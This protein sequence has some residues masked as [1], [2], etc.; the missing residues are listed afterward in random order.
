MFLGKT[1]I[2]L[3]L[4]NISVD[5]WGLFLWTILSHPRLTEQ[6]DGSASMTG[7]PT[8]TSR[9][10]GDLEPKRLRWFPADW[11]I[12]PLYQ[13]NRERKRLGFW[14][15]DLIA[16]YTKPNWLSK[17]SSSPQ[18]QMALVARL[19][20]W[21]DHHLRQARSGGLSSVEDLGWNRKKRWFSYVFM[22]C[23]PLIVCFSSAWFWSACLNL[24]LKQTQNVQCLILKRP[25]CVQCWLHDPQ[26]KS[27]WCEDLL[28]DSR[29]TEFSEACPTTRC[30]VYR[31]LQK[32]PFYKYKSIG[33]VLPEKRM[34]SKKVTPPIS[35][36]VDTLLMLARHL[37]CDLL[38]SAECIAVGPQSPQFQE[39]LTPI[40]CVKRF[41]VTNP[42]AKACEMVK[43]M[44]S[45]STIGYP[46]GITESL[47]FL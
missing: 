17:R 6:T 42:E 23:L 24:S 2:F 10:G 12:N 3:C 28:P 27:L 34:E 36:Q 29:A 16:I 35:K 22:G 46:T 43:V 13:Q 33:L 26:R 38:L 7:K 5:F 19:R 20:A 9:P 31:F 44:M 11:Y 47:S 8:W 4:F 15:F 18:I 1:L 32:C 14:D 39:R 37:L 21:L 25:A 41:Y 30:G 40:V 45:S